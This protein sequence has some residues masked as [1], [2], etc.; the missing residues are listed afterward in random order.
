MSLDA[1]TIVK[2]STF[3][4]EID[5]NNKNLAHFV[6]NPLE[7]GFGVTLG[8]SLRR[9][10]LSSLSG[11]AIVSC[12]ID[13]VSH[14]FSV[15]AGVKE[16]VCNIILNLKNITLMLAAGLTSKSISVKVVGPVILKAGDLEIDDDITVLNKDSTIC[17][18]EREIDFS[19]HIEVK[20]G[21]GYLPAR[22]AKIDDT[23]TLEGLG[24]MLIDASF[25]PIISVTYDVQPSG[26]AIYDKDKLTLTLETNGTIDPKKAL[27][28][29]ASILRNQMEV[30]I[31]TTILIDDQIEPMAVEEKNSNELPFNKY[32]LCK[33]EDL[34]LSVRSQNCLKCED[35]VYVGD[36]V[37]K[38][39]AEMLK[40]PNFGKKSLNEIKQVLMGMG[41]SLGMKI[42]EWPPENLSVLSKNMSDSSY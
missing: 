10:L 14:E 30:F 6:V 41:L 36:L 37:Q 23:F 22:L 21:K 13:G 38:T 26:S 18:I 24:C 39:E 19:L 40:T 25:S 2:P 29:A 9:V 16:D 34:E 28:I 5:S 8:N 31:D 15:I 42:A 17:S 32:L 3:D 11:D 20:K 12:T 35:V 27:G 4:I 7:R 1:L 33:I